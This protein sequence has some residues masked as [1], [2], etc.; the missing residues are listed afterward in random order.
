MFL[1]LK[2]FLRLDPSS[3]ETQNISINRGIVNLTLSK[4]PPLPIGHLLNLTD[5]QIFGLRFE[6]AFLEAILNNVLEPWWIWK[7]LDHQ[8]NILQVDEV[9]E[10]AEC[11]T[12][13]A[14]HQEFFNLEDVCL[15]AETYDG[16][17]GKDLGQGLTKS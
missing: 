10:K 6:N 9:R 17:G 8:I 12:K 3:N 15:E 5:T 13:S 11:W 7:F 4:W 16:S 2:I 1:Y 14:F